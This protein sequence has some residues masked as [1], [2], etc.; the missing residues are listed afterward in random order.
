MVHVRIKCDVTFNYSRRRMY[1]RR[2]AVHVRVSH[3]RAGAQG[4]LVGLK[5]T[6]NH[7]RVLV[8]NRVY[9]V[10]MRGPPN[11]H[12]QRHSTDN[13][14]SLLG[15]LLIRQKVS[16]RIGYKFVS[17]GRGGAGSS[18]RK[19]HSSSHWSLSD[20]ASLLAVIRRQESREQTIIFSMKRKL[21]PRTRPTLTIY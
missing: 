9:K 20:K 15:H 17:G 10:G 13:R 5:P 4:V 3:G 19:Y 7:R 16:L 8:D 6:V 2:T 18:Q 21:T 11:G 1:S 12:R 14:G